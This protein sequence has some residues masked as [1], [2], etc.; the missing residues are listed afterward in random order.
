MDVDALDQHLMAQFRVGAE[1]DAQGGAAGTLDYEI[2]C[3]GAGCADAAEP[4]GV[5][6]FPCAVRLAFE[7]WPTVRLGS[8]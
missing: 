2:D 7:A 5:D 8:R 1:W 6:G 4:L 3:Q